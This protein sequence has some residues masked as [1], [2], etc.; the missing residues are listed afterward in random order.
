[1]NIEEIKLICDTIGQLGADA[2]GAVIAWIVIT[3]L[4]PALLFAG[5]ATLVVLKGA[6]L[7][8]VAL[9]PPQD[10]AEALRRAEL[11]AAR[12]A[13]IRDLQARGIHPSPSLTVSADDAQRIIELERTI[14]MQPGETHVSAMRKAIA[15]V[16]A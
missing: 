15:Q 3:D 4:V 13:A 2:K 16:L 7:I 5:V 14:Y 9:N 10:A 1:M 11:H 12:L 6:A 8:R